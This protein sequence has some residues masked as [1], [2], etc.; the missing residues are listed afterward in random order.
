MT[1]ELIPTIAYAVAGAV[2]ALYMHKT[3]T[4]KLESWQL[5]VIA[6]TWPMYVGVAI[7]HFI[8]GGSR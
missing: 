6:L 7:L 4:D 1:I 5:G 2:V 8:T 3:Q